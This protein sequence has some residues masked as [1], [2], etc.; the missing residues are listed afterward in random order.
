MTE[1]PRHPRRPPKADPYGVRQ[2]SAGF[3]AE[4]IETYRADLPR[5]RRWGRQS[6]RG[7]PRNPVAWRKLAAILAGGCLLAILAALFS[8][9]AFIQDRYLQDIPPTPPK[10]QLDQISRAPAIRFLTDQE[11]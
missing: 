11:P 10:E 2:D 5:P 6:G 9:Y 1:D 4:P 3:D 8:G 7:G